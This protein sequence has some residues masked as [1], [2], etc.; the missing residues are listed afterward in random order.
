MSREPACAM[1]GAQAPKHSPPWPGEL[2]GMGLICLS[3]YSQKTD[4]YVQASPPLLQWCAG[5]TF[6]GWR[7]VRGT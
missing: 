6:R 3:L 2:S 4:V 1:A 5:D 7:K